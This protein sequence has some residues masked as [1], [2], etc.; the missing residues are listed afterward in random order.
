MSF[1]YLIASVENNS[2]S[3]AEKM[4][5]IALAN[6]ANESGVCFPSQKTIGKDTG[7]SSRHVY[8][9]LQTLKDNGLVQWHFE[10]DT[11]DRRRKKNI[12]RLNL[13]KITSDDGQHV[14]HD[15][16]ADETIYNDSLHG[17]PV[18]EPQR[19]DEPF[20]TAKSLSELAG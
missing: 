8:R 14:K 15:N 16:A 7:L 20:V 2:L 3:C 4:T 12:Y 10:H 9:C 13:E 17:H 19:N 1:N 11:Q 5:L 6:R 18:N